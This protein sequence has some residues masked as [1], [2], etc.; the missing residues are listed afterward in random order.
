[1]RNLQGRRLRVVDARQPWQ[2][3]VPTLSATGGEIEIMTTKPQGGP[4][5]WQRAEVQFTIDGVTYTQEEYWR[6]QVLQKLDNIASLLQRIA[7]PGAGGAGAPMRNPDQGTGGGAG[8]P[9][10]LLPCGHSILGRLEGTTSGA[11]P[12]C[13][14]SF[15]MSPGASGDAAR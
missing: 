1:M 14:Q 9:G 8:L 4:G 10:I 11:C 15:T 3:T 5:V 7:P 6:M 2:D 13:G 12:E